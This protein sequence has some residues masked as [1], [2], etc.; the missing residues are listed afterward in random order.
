MISPRKT[1]KVWL[2]L[3]LG[4]Q[5]QPLGE[6]WC[7]GRTLSGAIEHI[8]L[9]L[10]RS[11][12]H[13]L[14]RGFD[15]QRVTGKAKVFFDSRRGPQQNGC[16]VLCCFTV[17]DPFK[18][19]ALARCQGT[20][21]NMGQGQDF[22]VQ[23]IAHNNEIG[24]IPV[25]NLIDGLL[26]HVLAG[27]QRDR[28][29]GSGRNRFSAHGITACRLHLLIELDDVHF[30]LRK[31]TLFDPI[32]DPRPTTCTFVFQRPVYHWRVIIEARVQKLVHVFR[33]LVGQDD[34]VFDVA[35]RFVRPLA[36]V[37]IDQT[38]KPVGRHLV[39]VLLPELF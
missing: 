1:V 12:E 30:G 7:Q 2:S 15:T 34:H 11:F 25:P 27:R 39:T 19:L 18:N 21:A 3:P 16:D 13:G 24:T 38:V 26:A 14:G 31:R 37:A 5:M 8:H 6:V 22:E 32:L 28:P 36:R 9:I 33:W 17:A 4:S 35:Q 23:H 10:E 29:L 20:A